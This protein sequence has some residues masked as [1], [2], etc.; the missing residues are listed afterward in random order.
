MANLF[1]PKEK[2][3]VPAE[4]KEPAPKQA[5]PVPIKVGDTIKNG[6]YRVEIL[7]HAVTWYQETDAYGAIMF[8]QHPL[9]GRDVRLPYY[10]MK[11]WDD[12]LNAKEVPGTRDNPFI[13]W[14]HKTFTWLGSKYWTDET[15]WCKSSF[16]AACEV[17]GFKVGD[18]AL[19]IDG[20]KEGVAVDPDEAQHGDWCVLFHL[21]A[22]GN[23]NGKHHIAFWES[24]GDRHV[25]VRGGNQGNDINVTG[26]LKRELKTGSVRRMTLKQS[27]IPDIANRA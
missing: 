4:A 20:M 23:Y 8:R 17:A 21:D 12:Y 19:A 18:S 5:Q 6:V 22:N 11:F 26:F 7:G 15:A 16:N 3:A 27:M 1:K 10:V 9:Y 24:Y 25:Y 13:V 14:M 2:T